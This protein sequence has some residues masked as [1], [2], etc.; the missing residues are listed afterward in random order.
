M[1]KKSSSEG[2]TNAD[3]KNVN[4][5]VECEDEDS[6]GD[7][8]NF[9]KISKV[10]KKCFAKNK[11]LPWP[12]KYG[13]LPEPKLPGEHWKVGY[14]DPPPPKRQKSFAKIYLK[15]IFQKTFA[16]ISRNIIS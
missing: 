5:N 16:K 13:N 15:L 1:K 3:I 10:L 7:I 6:S 9:A 14:E 11:R 2:V 4:L 12:Q 8:K